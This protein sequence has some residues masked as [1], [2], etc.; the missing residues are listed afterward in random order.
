[1][2]N[3]KGRQPT[4]PVPPAQGVPDK[5]AGPERIVVPLIDEHLEVRKHWVQSGEVVVRR[6]VQTSQQTIPVELQYE[7]VQVDR[8]PVNRPLGEGEQTQPWWDGEVMVVP[9]IE[10]EIVVSK[11]LVVREEVRI[12]KRKSVRQET[13][14]D[15]IRNQQLHI[16]TTGALKPRDDDPKPR[17]NV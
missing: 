5:T 6:S 3:R 4:Q 1:M 2:T 16:D 13:V 7:E 14:S 10:E 17:N 15:T 9:V 8:V 11:R 12:S